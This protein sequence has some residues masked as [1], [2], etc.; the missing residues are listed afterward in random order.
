MTMYI[1]IPLKYLDEEC[2]MHVHY[3]QYNVCPVQNGGLAS[4]YIRV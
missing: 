2:E 3:I 1:A 4:V